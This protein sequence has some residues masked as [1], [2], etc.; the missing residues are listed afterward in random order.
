MIMK[1]V[2]FLRRTGSLTGFDV[3]EDNIIEWSHLALGTN[4]QTSRVAAPVLL[5]LDAHE[6]NLI[7][8]SYR[9]V[10]TT[11]RG[12]EHQAGQSALMFKIARVKRGESGQYRIEIRGRNRSRRSKESWTLNDAHSSS[13]SCPAV[14]TFKCNLCYA[15]C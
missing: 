2:S 7:T 11:N 6:Y 5:K 9:A 10:W 12:T 15:Q 3:V 4:G 1:H 8:L 14:Y 13:S